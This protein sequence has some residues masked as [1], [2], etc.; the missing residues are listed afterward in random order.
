V[1]LRIGSR[2]L[3]L[4]AP[5]PP[6]RCRH[7]APGHLVRTILCRD[8]FR[9]C[10]IKPEPPSR[11]ALVAA[12]ALRAGVRPVA[13][14]VRRLQSMVQNR[15]FLRRRRIENICDTAEIMSP[16]GMQS[17]WRNCSSADAAGAG[18]SIS[19]ARI[20]V[21]AEQRRQASPS[22]ASRTLPAIEASRLGASLRAH[23]VGSRAHIVRLVTNI[24]Q[25]AIIARSQQ[26]R[27]LD[28]NHAQAKITGDSFS[29]QTPTKVSSLCPLIASWT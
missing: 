4:C 23:R 29:K 11:A 15:R 13:V 17:G 27:H 26:R 7:H 20:V 8:C 6:R 2:F 1:V 12:G 14:R 10:A 22:S 21:P 16:S 19:S 3:P 5:R 24:C 28:R 9:R 25:S 18:R